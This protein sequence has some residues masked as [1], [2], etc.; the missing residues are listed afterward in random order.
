VVSATSLMPRM[1]FQLALALSE[2]LYRAREESRKARGIQSEKMKRGSETEST[3][4]QR[5]IERERGRE[6]RDKRQRQT[7]KHIHTYTHTHRPDKKTHRPTCSSG[8]RVKASAGAAEASC[9]RN[10]FA[11]MAFFWYSTCAMQRRRKHEQPEQ[12]ERH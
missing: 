7:N 12:Q 8:L 6:E 2:M 9:M 3:E 10:L 1:L 5:M 11:G 4:A